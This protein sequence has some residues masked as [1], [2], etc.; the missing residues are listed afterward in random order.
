MQRII[1]GVRNRY[2]VLPLFFNFPQKFI[3]NKYRI[4]I[5]E[6]NI[7]PCSY[8]KQPVELRK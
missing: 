4:I 2:L 8:L 1:A 7:K 6:V 3:D 5:N